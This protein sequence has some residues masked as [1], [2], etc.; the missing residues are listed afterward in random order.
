MDGR[1]EAEGEARTASVLSG[2]SLLAGG[3]VL[4]SGSVLTGG[5]SA[6]EPV[7]SAA[8]PG[9]RTTAPE[10]GRPDGDRDRP[11]PPLAGTGTPSSAP[12]REIRAATAS[13]AAGA[14]PADLVAVLDRVRRQLAASAPDAAAP[15]PAP[16]PRSA[17]VVAPPAPRPSPLPPATP[18]VPS[19][20][21]TAEVASSGTARMLVAVV[22]TLVTGGI[23]AWIG[24]IVLLGGRPSPVRRAL[25]WL[26]LLGGILWA[27]FLVLGIALSIGELD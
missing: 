22:L 5:R 24:G 15:R 11:A 18:G 26:F 7:P 21:S 23:G 17:T 9:P 3:S 20:P 16:P 27:A 25:G 19:I 12:S 13:A 4:S 1:D 6:D 2:S 10:A 14:V 8:P